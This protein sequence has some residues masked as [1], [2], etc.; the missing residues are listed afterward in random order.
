MNEYGVQDYVSQMGLDFTNVE[1]LK[2]YTVTGVDADKNIM[3][4]RVTNTSNGMPL[5]LIGT[6]G[7][8]YKVPS[9]KSSMFYTYINMLRGDAKKDTDVK[10]TTEDGFTN[11]ILSNGVFGPLS[12]DNPAFPA[13]SCYLP[14]PTSYVASAT[15]A[16]SDEIKMSLKESEV[17]LFNLRSG[18]VA[19]LPTAIKSVFRSQA[20]DEVDAWYNLNGQ[21]VDSPSKG[22]YIKNGVKVVIK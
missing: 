8:K 15:R 16:G 7:Q 14:V 5:L 9:V 11:C 22:I 4:T 21:R 12:A 18:S 1:G 20:S 2:A 13:G 19:D 10:K 17:I 6:A 3:L